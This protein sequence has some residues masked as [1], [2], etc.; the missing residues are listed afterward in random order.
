[1]LDTY[2]QLAAKRAEQGIPALPL[3][4]E[5]TQGLVELLM[6]PPKGE[7]AFLVDLLTN[8]VPPGV[9]AAARVKAGFLA[10]LA[11]GKETCPLI[12]RAKATELLGTM[13]GGYNV[14]PFIIHLGRPGSPSDLGLATIG[15]GE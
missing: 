10:S 11:K 1:M 15:K 4:A 13:L 7:E 12:S 9:D 6:A 5:Q 2:R 3:T 14:Q 8:R